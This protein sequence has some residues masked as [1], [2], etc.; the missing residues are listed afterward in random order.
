MPRKKPSME[1]LKDSIL[2]RR[3]EDFKRNRVKHQVN[4]NRT[5]MM[6][7][8]EKIHG[9]KIEDII[10]EGSIREVS[11][12]LDISEFTVSY[13]RKKFPLNEYT[14]GKNNRKL[15]VPKSN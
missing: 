2:S 4:C 14:V 15:P 12:K 8:L 6:D 3:V 5:P 11:E 1:S 7:L 13:W 10:W 9:G